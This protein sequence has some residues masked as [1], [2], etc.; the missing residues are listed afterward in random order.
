MNTVLQTAP[1]TDSELIQLHLA[2][3]ATAFRQIVERYQGMVCALAYSACGDV[4]RSEDL[5]QDVF[6]AA[7][8]QLPQLRE[9]DKLRGWLGGITRNLCHNA[10]RRSQRTPTAEAAELS[11]ETPADIADPRDHAIGEDEAALMWK[12]LAGLPENYRE[13]MVLFYREHHSVAAVAAALDISEDTAKQR[14]ARGRTLLTERMS[15]LVEETLT[16]TAPTLAFALNVL[17]VL[18]VTAPLVAES[19]LVA[20]KGAS[21]KTGAS[22]AALAAK[23]GILINAL[24]AVAALPALLNGL[25]D[26]LRFRA[27]LAVATSENRAGIIRSHVTPLLINAALLGGMALVFWV[28]LPAGWTTAL[29]ITLA[30]AVVGAAALQQRAKEQVAEAGKVGDAPAFEYR[31]RGGW[32][33]LPWVHVVA[34]GP[35]RQ[36]KAAGWIALSDGV[37]VGGLLASAPLAV[38]PIGLGGVAVG[39]LSLGGLAC[40]AGVVGVVAAGYW[41]AGG[42]AIAAQAAQGGLALATDFAT[43]FAALAAHANDAAAREFIQAHLFFRGTVSMWRVAVWMAFFGWL[44]P[45]LLIGWHLLQ[46]RKR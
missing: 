25:T 7:W 9:P 28:P 6:V 12:A 13:P 2:G 5:A 3:D 11:A 43:G 34:G 32:L 18:P 1:A 44:P 26:Y 46:S 36:R 23:G 8:K 21:A 39:L 33:G 35:W 29:L 37:A 19:V 4:A 45:L 17:M 15:R 22:A 10:F 40:G 24:A 14:L 16:R 27:H 42:M 41:A 38:A 30:V 20:G 31:S